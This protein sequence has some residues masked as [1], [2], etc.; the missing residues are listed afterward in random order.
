MFR[1]GIVRALSA[2]LALSFVLALSAMAAPAQ[3]CGCQ[4]QGG[5]VQVRASGGKSGGYGQAAR[6][7][8]DRKIL[9]GD[10]RQNYNLS[11]YITRGDLMVMLTRAFNFYS[12][13]GGGHFGDVNAWDY[14]YGAVQTMWRLGIARGDGR[15]F[16]PRSYV[17]LE[18]AILFIE[19]AMDH[20]DIE[21]T[22]D[23]RSLYDEDTLSDYATRE[24][25]CELL[26]YAL[27]GKTD[28]FDGEFGSSIGWGTAVVL[29]EYSV[30]EDRAV[31]LDGD[32]FADACEDALGED[33]SYLKF[34]SLP[35]ASKGALYCDYDEDDDGHDKASPGTAYDSGELSDITF[36]P[37]S[38]FSGK[39]TV[40]FRAYTEKNRSYSGRLT[41]TVGNSG[42]Y[43]AGV[44]AY[45]LYGSEAL[46]LDGD[47]FA[48][49]CGDAVG[50]D[51]SHL[52]FTF[53]LSASKGV[54]YYDYD[55][56]DETHTK[57]TASRSYDEDDLSTIV[58][59]PKSGYS[60]T[61]TFSY[62]G[63]SEDGTQ[64]A[65]TVK[66]TVETS[67]TANTVAYTTGGN[68]P[69]NLDGDDF[70]DVCV[71][72]VGEDFSHLKFTFL[73]SASKGVLY[74]DY[75]EDEDT[76][77][78]V[79]TSRSYDED[80]LSTI[81][82]VPKSGYE[83]SVAVSYTGY[84]EDGTQYA[85]SIEINVSGPSSA[86]TVVYLTDR[87][88]AFN[89][90]GDDFADTCGDLTGQDFSWLKFTSLPSS[91]KGALY[92]DSDGDGI[93][94]TRTAAATAYEEDELS[95]MVFVPETGYVGTVTIS[96]TGRGEDGTR[97][98]GT[99][100]ITVR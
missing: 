41:F 25:V 28:G 96:Y 9:R 82:F 53:L 51:F 65:G 11:G 97:Y 67:I 90:D 54:L 1:K 95:R 59:V 50:E 21:L 8:I 76:H 47:D 49:A 4:P 34:N 6:Y 30:G 70:A 84:T 39:V 22:V 40:S 7:M 81:A 33:F 74:Y 63:Y 91:A 71:D 73:P 13:G 42:S 20:T 29:V 69:L 86:D 80:D 37:A 88:E 89:L 35:S 24:D 58:F 10:G 77:T 66:I 44:I 57:V 32:D 75:D 94:E 99:V 12:Y 78:K 92:Y 26:Y 23:L 14:Y 15:N 55:V 83:G 36:V 16:M 27:T 61:V 62:T 60:G 17:T 46:A 56:D 98:T 72:A 45:Q 43:E 68:E 93:Y 38:G 87:N 18:Q 3:V 19:R 79:T 48:G 31:A 85:G 2:G 5:Q 52:K 100:R 64:Y